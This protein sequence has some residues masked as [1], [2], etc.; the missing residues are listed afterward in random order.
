ML[1][2]GGY[3]PAEE[4]EAS[5]PCGA[6]GLASGRQV[7][8][9]C[10]IASGSSCLSKSTLLALATEA[11]SITEDLTMVHLKTACL[12]C[13]DND[14]WSGSG[15]E[16]VCARCWLGLHANSAS[17]ALLAVA[18][19]AA[20]DGD[21]YDDDD[22]DEDTGQVLDPIDGLQCAEC[23]SILVGNMCPVCDIHN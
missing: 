19:M 1:Q 7:C 23:D 6:Q 12:S 16:Q 13:G 9:R 17:L 15:P 5:C 11:V 22:V 20:D 2:S 4:R 21:Y 10:F 8:P 14:V 3:T 18:A